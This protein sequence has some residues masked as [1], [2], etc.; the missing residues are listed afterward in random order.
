MENKHHRLSEGEDIEKLFFGSDEFMR[1]PL[2]FTFW[3]YSSWN[4][5]F[6]HYHWNNIQGEALTS[7][8]SFDSSTRR[9]RK[10]K[11]LDHYTSAFFWELE[12][13]FCHYSWVVLLSCL[14]LSCLTLS[15]W[16]IRVSL[17]RNELSANRKGWKITMI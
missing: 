11:H 1:S 16:R 9:K 3:T 7:E 12:E 6:Y 4:I 15:A 14:N 10:Q 17:N 13:R 2:F 8:H 5:G